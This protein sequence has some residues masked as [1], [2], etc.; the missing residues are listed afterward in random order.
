VGQ[1]FAVEIEDRGLGLSDDQLATINHL[2]ETPPP[3]DPSSSDQLGL[4]VAGQLAKRHNIKISMRHSPYGGTTAIVLIPRNLVISEE[5]QARDP[6]LTAATPGNLPRIKARHA[7]R[8]RA[9]TAGDA[10]IGADPLTFA[11]PS[12]TSTWPGIDVPPMRGPGDVASLDVTG[13]D[14]SSPGPGSPGGHI[15]PG[16]GYGPGPGGT[17]GADLPRRVRQ[18]SLAP[19]LRD[20]T[21]DPMP[22][23]VVEDVIVPSP[24]E[25]R[26][27][28]S[29]IQHGWERGRSVFD[30]PDDDRGTPLGAATPT[31]DT[32]VTEVHRGEAPDDT[33][34]SSG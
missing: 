22:T 3:F 30:V 1:G 24:E 10:G 17:D 11:P 5:D 31:G 25:A 33:G 18:A 14:Y 12:D 29:A 21:I 15:S 19:Q 16:A 9:V 27:T 13:L 23:P 26:S 28:M 20:N 7:T 34:G 2:L 6:A 8:D 4:F 32:E